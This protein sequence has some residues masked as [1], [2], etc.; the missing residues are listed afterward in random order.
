MNFLAPVLHS[1]ASVYVRSMGASLHVTLPKPIVRQYEL[2][3]GDQAVFDQDG[4]GLR[5][6]F[7]RSQPQPDGDCP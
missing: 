1:L 6:R 4:D 5:L 3:A 7:L 2:R